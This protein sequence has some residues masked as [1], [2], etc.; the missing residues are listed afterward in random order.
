MCHLN[1]VISKVSKDGYTKYIHKS[2]IY[3]FLY[4]R[5]YFLFSSHFE[6]D[7]RLTRK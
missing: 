7:P 4:G 6:D 1:L 2:L 3:V 5:H